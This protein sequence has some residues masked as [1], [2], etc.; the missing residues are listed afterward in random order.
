MTETEIIK[1]FTS[2]NCARQGAGYAPHKPILILLLLEKILN[3]HVNEFQFSEL[4]HD[5]KKLLEKYGSPN[6]STTRNE[7]FWRLKNDD[8]VIINAPQ[9]LLSQETTPSPNQLIE[10]QASI[11][12]R[13]DIY[14]DIRHNTD[15]IRHIATTLLEKFVAVPYRI[16]M[17]ADTAPTIKR[18]ER[19]Y[20]WVSQN[21]TYQ[22]EVPGNFMWS[23]KTNRDGGSNPSYNFM[24]QM[25]VGDIVFSFA[26]TY[27]KA[28]G[29]VTNEATS[30]IKPDFGAAGANWLN[31]G[32]LVDVAFEE[33]H[34]AAFRPIE[35]IDL[36]ASLLPEMY[37]P[38]RTNGV[39]NQIYLAKIPN[40]MADALFRIAGDTARAIEQDLS[41]DVRYEIPAPDVEVET[42]IQMRTDIGATQKTQIINSRRGQG[43]FKANVRLIE[44]ACRVTGVNNPRHLIASH[45]KPWS[46]SDDTE[47]LSGFNGLLLSPHIDHLFDKGL[48]SFENSGELI[49]SKQFDHVLLDKWSI[50]KAMN[51]GSFKPEQIHFLSY[52][53][54][55][56]LR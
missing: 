43:V 46:K 42:E 53:R 35:H 31:D 14:Q 23:P 52:H 41:K 37:S 38:I 5:L 1:L 28:I 45:I 3:G 55:V 12:L 56:V 33:L 44:T 17:L 49:L 50:N 21:Q 40:A 7:P 4:D 10:N 54:D 13:E 16:P 34:Q 24:T 19:N 18:F 39:G 48:I 51:A 25:K 29:I 6:A 26:N 22:H 27:I 9:F 20:W 47:K 36:L 2:I 11:C 30:S 15:L 8:L 32:W